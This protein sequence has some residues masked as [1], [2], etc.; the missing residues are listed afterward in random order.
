M[1]GLTR[2][3]EIGE[4]L[5]EGKDEN[6]ERGRAVLSA[7]LDAGGATS[8]TRIPARQRVHGGGEHALSGRTCARKG[9]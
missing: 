1:G 2:G 4:S 9:V 5:K 8:V 3:G 6:F 7:G